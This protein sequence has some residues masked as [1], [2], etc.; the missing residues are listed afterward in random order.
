MDSLMQVTHAKADDD[1]F[2]YR[3]YAST[4]ADEFAALGLPEPMLASLLRMQFQAQRHS[5]ALQYP[6]AAWRIVQYGGEKAGYWLTHDGT[7]ALRLVYVALLPEYR[8]RGAGT[9]LIRRLQRQA[10]EQGKPL[11]LQVPDNSPARRLYRRL[12]FR[13]TGYD[14]PYVAME[15]IPGGEG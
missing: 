6:T 1:D 7:D 10:N 14:P 8:N 2:M 4:R 9:E 15:W 5:Y 11:R 12:G 13:E 3:V